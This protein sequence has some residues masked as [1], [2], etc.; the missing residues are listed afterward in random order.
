MQLVLTP[1]PEV[2][3]FVVSD[4]VLSGWVFAFNMQMPFVLEVPDRPKRSTEVLY[5]HSF[6]IFVVDESNLKKGRLHTLLYTMHTLLY[7]H[8]SVRCCRFTVVGGSPPARASNA[9]VASTGP[10]VQ[11]SQALV[12]TLALTLTVTLT[13]TQP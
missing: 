7:N 3:A 9:T 4:R 1:D 5:G 2:E 11:P 13:L 8:S 10:S 6:E 12:L